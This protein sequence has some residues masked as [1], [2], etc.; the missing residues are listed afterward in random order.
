MN[1]ARA[2]ADRKR[3]NEEVSIETVTKMCKGEL[4]TTQCAHGQDENPWHESSTRKEN[5]RGESQRKRNH[6]PEELKDRCK[7]KKQQEDNINGQLER[8]KWSKEKSNQEAA[9]RTSINFSLKRG[10]VVSLFILIWFRDK[11]RTTLRDSWA[12][13]KQPQSRQTKKDRKK[14]QM[15]T[16]RTKRMKRRERTSTHC[17]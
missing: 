15:R 11:C 8:W 16:R 17:V 6:S 14:I 12:E 9:M 10:T 2:A 3:Q 5:Q 7:A 1:S 4:K 13:R